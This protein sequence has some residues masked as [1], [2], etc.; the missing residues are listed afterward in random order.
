MTKNRLLTLLMV[1]AACLVWLSIGGQ[2]L[3]TPVEA[4]QGVNR[5]VISEPVRNSV[6]G[7]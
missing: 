5:V 1:I 3:M 7:A 4:Q 2:S 6:C